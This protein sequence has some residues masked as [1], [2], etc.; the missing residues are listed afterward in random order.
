MNVGDDRIRALVLGPSRAYRTLAFPGRS[1]VRIAVRALTEREIDACRVE[2]QRQ[3]LD[4]CRARGW[5]PDKAINIDPL[6]HSRLVERQIVWRAFFDPDTIAGPDP[7]PFFPSDSDVAE[8]DSITTTDL[9]SAYAEHQEFVSPSRGLSPEEVERMIDA[10]GKG[11]EPAV[12]LR[13]IE[14]DSLVSFALSM[15]RRLS[16]SPTGR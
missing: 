11:S 15:A 5:D 12:V 8:L 16:I 1:E 14:R 7:R 2:G 9:V 3:F 13:T 10:M 4:L 6:M